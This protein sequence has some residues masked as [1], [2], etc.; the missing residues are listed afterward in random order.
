MLLVETIRDLAIEDESFAVAVLPILKEFMNS[1]GMSEH[2][3]CMVA[4]TRVEA[5]HPKLKTMEWRD[6]VE[7][8]VTS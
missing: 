7:E 4:V 8:G 1:H 3:S 5:A 6:G 2:D